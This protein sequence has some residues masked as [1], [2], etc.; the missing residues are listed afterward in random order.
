MERIQ[1]AGRDA[2]YFLREIRRRPGGFLLRR[3]GRSLASASRT[4][5]AAAGGRPY[6]AR[7]S[8]AAP[9]G[10]L[11]RA[12][13]IQ[14]RIDYLKA[15]WPGRVR[16]LLARAER[17]ARCELE[18][19][20][21][22]VGPPI[23]WHRDPG[24]ERSWPM[25]FHA[26]Y[27]YGD[28]LD[29]GRRT[30]IKLPWELSRLQCLPRLALAFRLSGDERY[31]HAAR[32]IL[33]DWDRCNPVG[34]G[35]N[36]TVGMEAG[37]RAM[38]IILAS[39][40]CVGT[41]VESALLD[42]RVREM[43]AEHG[44]FL[45]RNVERSDVNGN[46]FTGC[47]LGLLYLG[48]QAR[49]DAESLAWLE[50]AARQLPLAIA[51]Q[52]YPDG[53]CHEGSIPYH[54]FV[55]EMFAHALLVSGQVGIE[56]PDGYRDRFSAMLAFLRACLKPAGRVPI[57]GDADDGRVLSLG[58]GL[59][60]HH[61]AILAFGAGLL[62]RP[63]LW[64]ANEPVPVAAALLLDSERALGLTAGPGIPAGTA[65]GAGE[66]PA[67]DAPGVA[68]SR[69]AGDVS[70][71]DA[72]GVADSRPA[73]E[74]PVGDAPPEAD[75]RRVDAFPEGGFFI[76]RERDSYCLI[77][78]GD[79]GLRGRGGHGHNDAL[80][81][82]LVLAGRDVLTDTGCASYTRSVEERVAC[83]SARAHNSVC[84][85]DLE[86]AP[87]D[88]ARIPHACACPVELIALDERGCA[89]VGRHTGYRGRLPVEFCE[90]RVQLRSDPPEAIIKDTIAG[91]GTHSVRWHFH[92]ATDWAP[93]RTTADC[94]SFEAQGTE[95]EVLEIGWSLSGAEAVVAES[96]LYSSYARETTRS[97]LILAA[98]VTLP[99]EVDFR[100]LLKTRRS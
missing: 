6:G 57:W 91:A 72:P 14:A 63:D 34:Y 94:A 45:F 37:L 16:G 77:D 24:A 96:R 39:E 100:F 2:I 35:I 92:L 95:G 9:P 33:A 28:L 67:V 74:A 22:P 70:A 54:G 71:V 84:I 78:C 93:C 29:V 27:T 65:P 61:R 90:R 40:L 3:A 1:S 31:V 48:A 66:A 81:V 55:T 8:L 41:P 26:R 21:M 18:V 83:L 60:E 46:H 49:W 5:R 4:L 85:D 36:W 75:S 86:P 88:R 19:L 25:R 43:L 64:Y 97:C 80:S 30:D 17:D 98:S 44:R 62:S 79:V 69:P 12:A 56:V 52:V 89:F 58:G 38:S 15:R 10:P 47:L 82:E 76:L 99:L 50:Y 7:R 42:G 73:G 68:D 53:V 32:A 51:D 13:D 59:D 20:S 87:I 23:D 11:L